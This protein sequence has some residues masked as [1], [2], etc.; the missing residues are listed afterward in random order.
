MSTT[1]RHEPSEATQCIAAS[2]GAH[3][4]TLAGSGMEF[5]FYTAARDGHKEGYRIPRTPV[6]NTANNRGV[7]ALDLQH[8]EMALAAWAAANEYPAPNL[9]I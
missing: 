6:F 4:V 8:Q 1:T 5:L 2:R 7:S 3:K 9:W